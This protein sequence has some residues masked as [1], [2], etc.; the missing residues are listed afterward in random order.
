M[1]FKM[2]GL[3]IRSH[4]FIVRT[5]MQIRANEQFH[6]FAEK[7]LHS[8]RVTVWCSIKSNVRRTDI[9]KTSYTTELTSQTK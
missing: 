2:F 4:L 3:G 8:E 6:C 9:L 5:R 7:L 1:L